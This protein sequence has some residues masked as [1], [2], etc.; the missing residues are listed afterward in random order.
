VALH[1]SNSVLELVP[2]AR[3]LDPARAHHLHVGEDLSIGRSESDWVV[4]GEAA[5][6]IRTRA[7]PATGR[8]SAPWTDDHH[9]LF[10]VLK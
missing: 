3:A 5:P 1:V 7:R 2:V 8:A 4:L 9:D 10:S 6:A